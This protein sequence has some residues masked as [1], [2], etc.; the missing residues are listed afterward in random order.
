MRPLRRASIAR[1]AAGATG[2]STLEIQ[3]NP[4]ITDLAPDALTYSD[5]T[6]RR[7]LGDA[8]GVVLLYGTAG[9]RFDADSLEGLPQSRQSPRGN[10]VLAEPGLHGPGV[11]SEADLQEP[12]LTDELA[13]SA[14]AVDA[15]VDPGLERLS[16]A[17]TIRGV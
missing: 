15:L 9:I 2:S 6:A 4:T 10:E 13:Q 8:T 12:A 5:D 16:R 3:G 7:H 1:G 14:L 11:Q 17:V